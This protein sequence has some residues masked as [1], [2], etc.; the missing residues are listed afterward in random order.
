MVL[1]T[2]IPL[3]DVLEERE[4]RTGDLLQVPYERGIIEVQMTSALTAR[5][6]RLRTYAINDYLHPCLQPGME[7]QLKWHRQP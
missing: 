6:V 3:E 1:Y 4:A 2:P 5:I 7:I